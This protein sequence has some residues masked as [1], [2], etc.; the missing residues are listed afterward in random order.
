[1]TY[2]TAIGTARFEQEI[3]KSRFIGIV[4]P[5]S[6]TADIAAALDETG[7]EFRDATHVAWAYVLGDPNDGPTMRA[8]DAGEPSGTAGRPILS[9]LQKR[10]LGGVLVLVV[11]YFG[12]VKLG[13][14][15]LVRAYSGTA[16]GALDRVALGMV[17]PF[18][19]L[20]L[21]LDYADEQPV[22]RLL[23]ERGVEILA[24]EF[25]ERVVLSASAPLDELA[26]LTRAIGER[27]SGRATIVP[28]ADKI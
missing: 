22:R 17:R 4:R 8:D 2:R 6:T 26:A 7:S 28:A 19:D 25:G 11:R 21:R 20:R 15:G 3:K 16:N 23:A 9:A 18:S 1:M 27:T 12:G 14:G 5:V 13:A 24:V 10:G